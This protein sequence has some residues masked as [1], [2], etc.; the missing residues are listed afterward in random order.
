MLY[1]TGMD[2]RTIHFPQIGV[3][4]AGFSGN[5]CNMHL[6][7]LASIVS[8]ALTN[9]D[10]NPMTFQT[11]GVSDAISMGTFGTNF[12]L[13]SRDLIADC[14]ETVM[15]GPWYDGLVSDGESKP[16]EHQSLMRTSY[17]LLCLQ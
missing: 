4:S 8:G 10:L 2:E 7:D 16:S 11:I 15:S 17:A 1:A 14:V 12:S 5:P 9:H 13:P 6:D 3:A